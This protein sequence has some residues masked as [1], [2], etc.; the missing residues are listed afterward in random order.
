MA[1]IE[2]KHF[3]ASEIDIDIG[4]N[5]VIMN[6][7][8]A[9]ELGL[10]PNTRV[11]L[12][13]G[14]K[15]RGA[16][17]ALTKTM[18][19][20]GKILVSHDVAVDL[21][22]G[23]EDT[24]GVKPVPVPPS[25]I[26]LQKRLHGQ[27][28]GQDEMYTLIKDVVD[29]ILSEA[30]IAAFLTSQIYYELSEDE[31][32]AL[33]K[34]MVEI[35]SKIE[36]EDT[37]YDEHSIGGVPGNS[38]VA[39]IAVPTISSAGLLI[40][41]TSSRAITSPAGTAD[42]MEVLARVDLTPDEIKEVARKVRATLAWGG[43]LNLAPADD[44]FVNIE[45]KLSIDPWHQMVASILAKKVAMGV[46]N[47][48]VDI[49]VGRKAKVKDLKT[50]DQLAGLFIRQA[51]RLGMGIRVAITFGGQPIG[52]TAGPA[53]EAM[54]ALKAMI[55]RRGSKSLIEKALSIAG[56]VIELSGKVSPGQ[57]VEVARSIFE[58]GKTY[59]KFKQIIEAQGGNP[60]IKH[61]DLPIGSHTYTI[62][63]PIE[64]AVTHI[65]NAAITAI[66]RAAGAP[67]DKG[68]G[69]YLHAKIG[70]RVNRGDPLMTIYSSSSVRLQEALNIAT[71]YSPILVE[72]ML[73]KILP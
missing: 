50:A 56:L 52:R 15:T 48:V 71:R 36:F 57:G 60:D 54:E 24:I 65:D 26:G 72:G 37:V 7:V 27:R 21:R 11:R 35:G 10:G 43:K 51:A 6:E 17:I 23:K 3:L 25:F 42:T 41:K 19:P 46:D 5:I 30:E 22:L 13:K 39:L 20:Q 67:F 44:I 32:N 45:R 18:V 73:I 33:I 69:V 49:P 4:K 1:H 8:D 59:E 53:L 31:L 55:E 66:A 12:I 40:P 14:D 70:Y 29:G 38:K 62:E 64:G 68:A 28:L 58:S 16:F 63:A 61:D 47:L 9:R 2:T 34:A